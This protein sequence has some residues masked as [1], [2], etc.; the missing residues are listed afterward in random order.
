MKAELERA[1]SRNKNEVDYVESN[2]TDALSQA[3]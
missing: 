3:C 1:E 2:I